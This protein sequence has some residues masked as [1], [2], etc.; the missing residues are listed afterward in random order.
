MDEVPENGKESS[1]SGH[2]NG[3]IRIKEER[4]VLR[5]IKRRLANWIGHILL[6]NCLLKHGFEG[7]I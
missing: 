6:R 7:H 4:N 3:I 1:H 5:A 2:A